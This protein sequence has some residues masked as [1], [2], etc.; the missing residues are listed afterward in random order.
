MENL[1][2]MCNQQRSILR[3]CRS[4]SLV[5]CRTPQ[6]SW[7]FAAKEILQAELIC[8]R[9]RRVEYNGPLPSSSLICYL[10]FYAHH[11]KIGTRLHVRRCSPAKERW[12]C[13]VWSMQ[14]LSAVAIFRGPWIDIGF[15][16]VE[17]ISRP[18][19]NKKLVLQTF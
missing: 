7:I 9:C 15:S 13:P 19:R 6:C 5:S 1:H 4:C 2:N 8:V 11:L 12:Q 10:T 16:S 18:R 14:N 3:T 17:A